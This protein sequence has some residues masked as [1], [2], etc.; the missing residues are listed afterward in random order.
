M[1][2]LVLR[3]S[4]IGDIILTTPVVRALKVQ[5]QAE[6][7]YA[8]KKEYSFLMKHNPYVDKVHE[9]DQELG[10][11][12]SSLKK[13]K[14]DWVIDLHHNLRTL[15][16][17][18]A[19]GVKSA[20]FNK[21]N[22]EKWLMVNFKVNRLPAVHIVDRY[23]ETTAH[24]GVVPDEEG[25]DYFISESDDVPIEWLP[26]P[27]RKGFVVFAIGGQHGTKKL[28]IDRMIELCDKINRPVIVL[29]GKEDASVGEQIEKFFDRSVSADRERF[30]ALGKKTIV[31][32]GCGKFN[33]NQSASLV[34]KAS[35]VFTHDTGLMHV[36]AAFQKPVFSIWGNTI[37]AFGMYPY[38][39]R[40]IV[41]ENARLG[42]R[43]CSKIGF[44]SCPKGHF[45]C[46]KGIQFD[47]YLGP[48]GY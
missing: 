4:S 35:H 26:E 21:L 18:W 44:K 5:L 17:K 40:F 1:K 19:L 34:E 32:N 23:L 7:H 39:T 15:R 10:E 41:L 13:E 33:F 48:D 30:E 20:S 9:L 11:L 43:P 24:L 22:L 45:Q 14:F 8:I 27:F 36:A 42:C 16:V 25:L 28:P 46:M 37:P 38:R 6:V 47:F 29:G 2:I 3:F 31:F 12:T